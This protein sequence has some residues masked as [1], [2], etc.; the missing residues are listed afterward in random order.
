LSIINNILDSN[1]T[2]PKKILFENNSLSNANH[3][4]YT[5]ERLAQ[6]QYRVLNQ[7]DTDILVERL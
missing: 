1:S 2:L 6:Y 5:L 3:V 4:I 7:G